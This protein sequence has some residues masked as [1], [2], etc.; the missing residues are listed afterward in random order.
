MCAQGGHG[1]WFRKAF[2]KTDLLEH[3][4][5]ILSNGTLTIEVTVEIFC[6]DKRFR[7]KRCR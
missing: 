7:G 1:K 3:Q 4:E 2:R 6:P 5:E